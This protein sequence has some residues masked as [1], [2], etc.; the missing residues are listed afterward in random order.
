MLP[1]PVIGTQSDEFDQVVIA[2]IKEHIAVS[3]TCSWSCHCFINTGI[4]HDRFDEHS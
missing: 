4:N 2:L 3:W 1:H